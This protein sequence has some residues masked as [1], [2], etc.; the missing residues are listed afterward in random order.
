MSDGKKT[1][2]EVYN[3]VLITAGAVGISAA[4]KKILREPLGTPENIK[5][6]L[7]LA[8]SVSA[9]TLLVGFLKNKK[10]IPVDPFK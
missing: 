9:S 5:G 4:S 10:Y 1:M 3:A 7:K 6:F 2:N 8:V